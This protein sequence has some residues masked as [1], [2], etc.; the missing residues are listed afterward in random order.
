MKNNVFIVGLICLLLFFTGICDAEETRPRNAQ[1]GPEPG[2]SFPLG[3]AFT[4]QFDADIDNNGGK[5]SVDRIFLQGGTTYA[6]E[7]RRS[8]SLSLGYGFDGYDFSGETGFS[9]LR[10]WKDIN[11]FRISTPIL[12]GLEN[13]WTLFVIPS[14]RFTGESGVSLGDGTQGGLFAGASY[15]FGDRLTLGPGIGVVSQI[16]DSASVFPVL[17]IDWKITDSL[18]LGTGRGM[19][20]TLGPGLFLN[21][22]ASDKWR[23]AFG[24]RYEKLRFR[25]NG[26]GVAPDGVGEDRSFPLLA[27]VTYHFTPRIQ[28]SLLGG[29]ELGGKLELDDKNGNL[30]TDEDYDTAGFA[31]FTIRGRF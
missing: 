18:S 1:M 13:K 19:G 30:I 22:K 26:S 11:T 9:G 27:G 17:L 21:W 29:V 10:P 14:A 8:I 15:R 24:G 16:E 3:G 20:A 31:G 4:H 23:V 12:W 25:L 28:V 6:I 5:F 2:W 7:K